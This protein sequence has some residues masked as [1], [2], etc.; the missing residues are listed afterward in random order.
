[1][2][3]YVVVELLID[4][5]EMDGDGRM[6]AVH[7]VIARLVAQN[8]AEQTSL[9]RLR[10]PLSVAVLWPIRRRRPSVTTATAAAIVPT[11]HG[12]L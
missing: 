10:Q 2:A 9:C 7:V 6:K 11:I 1:M 5:S 8:G 4:L 3:P 12:R